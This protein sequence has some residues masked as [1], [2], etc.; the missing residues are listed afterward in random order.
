MSKLSTVVWKSLSSILV[1]EEMRIN[2]S[3]ASVS[4]SDEPFEVSTPPLF[5]IFSLVRYCTPLSVLCPSLS[6]PSIC[7]T[8]SMTETVAR[9]ARLSAASNEMAR[10]LS[11]ERRMAST[12][13]ACEAKYSRVYVMS[14]FLNLVRATASLSESERW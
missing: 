2:A 14:P 8:L 10:F 6:C 11:A 13:S 5:T 1:D 3:S 4:E 12:S 7:N 9:S